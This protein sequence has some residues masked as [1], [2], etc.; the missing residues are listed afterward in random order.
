MFPFKEKILEENKEYILV[1]RN[2]MSNLTSEELIW[3]RDREDREVY[4][5]EGSGWY[6]QMD[7]EIPRLMEKDI[8]FNIPKTTWHRIINKNGTNLVINV[9][10]YK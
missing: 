3:H 5:V 4:L 8:V 2:F 10:K 1:Q 9:R 6:F 7:N